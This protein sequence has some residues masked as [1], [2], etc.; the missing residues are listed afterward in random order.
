[1]KR[2]RISYRGKYS[3][4]V[5]KQTNFII[6]GSKPS[7]KLLEK[8]QELKMDLILYSTLAGIING[9]VDPECTAFEEVPEIAEHSQGYN[10]PAIQCNTNLPGMEEVAAAK[11][12]FSGVRL[13]KCKEAAT[14]EGTPERAH[15]VAGS[16]LIGQRGVLGM[17]KLRKKACR[18]AS[19]VH[20]T[21]WVLQGDIKD[22]I[23]ELLFMGLDTLRVED[24]RVCFLHPNNPSLHAKKATGH[25]FQVSKDSWFSI[26]AS[27]TSRTTLKRDASTPTTSP[28]G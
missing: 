26:R 22:L 24:K 18:Y 2:L 7:K 17:S 21:L 15:L 11:V 19:V 6:V 13:R 14:P 8:A 12:T 23:M 9:S 28:S 1:L 27:P 4:F 5:T 25:T 10:H 16:E 3:G 20:A